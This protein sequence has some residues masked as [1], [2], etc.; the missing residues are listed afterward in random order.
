MWH[1]VDGAPSTASIV[2]PVVTPVRC[3][4]NTSSDVTNR[5][6]TKAQV[7]ASPTPTSSE[8]HE[9]VWMDAARLWTLIMMLFTHPFPR[10]PQIRNLTFFR[11]SIQ[12]LICLQD[13]N[14]MLKLQ[15]AFGVIAT[16][17]GCGVAKGIKLKDAADYA[18]KRD[19]LE[20]SYPAYKSFRGLMHSG[21]MPAAIIDDK[22][23]YNDFSSYFFVLYRPDSG[24]SIFHN[25]TL[26]VWLNG[27]PGVSSIWFW[28]SASF[29]SFAP[30]PVIHTYSL[31]FT[32]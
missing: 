27:G 30:P 26:L 29:A 32:L 15:M 17:I 18:I 24:E 6:Y 16:S 9:C 14:S 4:N 8:C 31:L 2:S 20:R 22:S 1:V 3:D 11:Q 25:D 23:S 21:L 10:P 12:H 7:R 19:L 13:N 5:N 28:K